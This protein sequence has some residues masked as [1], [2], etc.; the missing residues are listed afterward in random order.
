MKNVLFLCT[1]NSCR[2][3]MAEGLLNHL[4]KGKYR[5]FSAGSN[6]TGKVHPMSLATLKKHGIRDYGYESKSWDAFV[7]LEALDIVITVC[8]NAAGEV[9]PIFPGNPLKA[10]WGVPDSAH[11][12][13]TPE[14]VSA[15][16]DRVFNMLKVKIETLVSLPEMSRKEL[17]ANLRNIGNL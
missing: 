16:F 8:D 7:N 9:C 11:F 14:A 10:H 15:E 4:G 13:G 5:G 2:S 1:G 6:P 3:I 12:T 17:T